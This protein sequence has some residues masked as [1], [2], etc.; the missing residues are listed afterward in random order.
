MD[1]LER[2]AALRPAGEGLP[3]AGIPD[4][5]HEIVRLRC[6]QGSCVSSFFVPSRIQTF[7]PLF[8]G[9]SFGSGLLVATS[10]TSS[11]FE[12]RSALHSGFLAKWSCPILLGTF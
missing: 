1:T 4:G 9:L 11:I 6:F 2:L 12:K 5:L 8:R 3:T 10:K 7:S